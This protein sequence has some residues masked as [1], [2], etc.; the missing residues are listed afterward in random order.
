MDVLEYNVAFFFFSV[1]FSKF[2]QGPSLGCLASSGGQ[3]Q[4]VFWKLQVYDVLSI[5]KDVLGKD[6]VLDKDSIKHCND[7]CT[8]IQR[9]FFFSFQLIS[10]NSAKDQALAAL[11]PVAA[12]AKYV[13]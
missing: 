5:P 13:F 6:D 8:R 4:Y 2:S 3:A 11:P 9:S 1:N 12:R 10:Q 7:G